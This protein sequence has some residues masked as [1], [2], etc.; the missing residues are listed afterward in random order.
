MKRKTCLK[1]GKIKKLFAKN[2]AGKPLGLKTDLFSCRIE[3]HQVQGDPKTEYFC[4]ECVESI[5]FT[6]IEHGKI[7]CNQGFICDKCLSEYTKFGAP[8]N[9]YNSIEAFECL[10]SAGSF[11]GDFILQEQLLSSHPCRCGGKWRLIVGNSPM[12]SGIAD[13]GYRCELC[14]YKKW[15]RFRMWKTGAKFP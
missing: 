3:P 5:V 8:P 15:F 12:P 10:G 9:G 11:Q 14:G 2:F 4:K 13:N 6:C 7:K 1:C